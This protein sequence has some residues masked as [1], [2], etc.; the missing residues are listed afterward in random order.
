MNERSIALNTWFFKKWSDSRKSPN[1]RTNKETLEPKFRS[2][3]ENY[4]YSLDEQRTTR[5]W[6]CGPEKDPGTLGRVGGGGRSPNPSSSTRQ[7]A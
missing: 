4:G 6:M 7:V 5:E 3:N 2:G 1:M